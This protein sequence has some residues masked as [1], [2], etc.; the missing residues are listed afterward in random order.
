[1]ESPRESPGPGRAD[2]SCT[3]DAAGRL[4]R[5]QEFGRFF[6]AAVLSADRPDPA[7]LILRLRPEQHAGQV[8]GGLAAAETAC[9]SFFRF[10]LTATAG[11]LTLDVTVPP[12]HAAALDGLAR[13]RRPG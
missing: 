4:T 12:D 11:S 3:L 7:T 1:M 2:P 8:A 6:A 10:V 9:C 5:T 13:A